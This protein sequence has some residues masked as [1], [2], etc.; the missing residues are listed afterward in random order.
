MG[1]V[2]EPEYRVFVE[3]PSKT[4]K[5]A[6][7]DAVEAIKYAAEYLFGLYAIDC[8]DRG[9]F[10]ETTCIMYPEK[11]YCKR[12]VIEINIPYTK[13]TI[14]KEKNGD[15]DKDLFMQIISIIKEQYNER[16]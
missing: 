5:S 16:V 7:F 2:Y 13:I 14:K 12:Y 3:T 9:R 10:V 4:H 15:I 8:L 1:V 11:I 6:P